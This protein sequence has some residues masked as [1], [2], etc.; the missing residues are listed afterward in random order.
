MGQDEKD[1]IS[2]YKLETSCSPD[3]VA[4]FIEG[5]YSGKLAAIPTWALEWCHLADYLQCTS[6]FEKLK[7]FVR[8]NIDNN[9][10]I[11]AW[12]FGDHFETECLEFVSSEYFESDS[13][14]EGIASLG[15]D[16]F[17][18]LVNC[19]PMTKSDEKVEL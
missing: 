19:A 16:K 18:K 4:K 10:L 8:E 13:C 7:Q 6:T 1:G 12:K 3:I 15:V 2:V 14:L 9:I 11:P 17:A 5:I